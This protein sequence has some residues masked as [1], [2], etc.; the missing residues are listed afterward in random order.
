MKVWIRIIRRNPNCETSQGFMPEFITKLRIFHHKIFE[1]LKSKWQGLWVNPMSHR[2][3]IIYL[4]LRGAT[5]DI[6]IFVAHHC[7]SHRRCHRRCMGFGTYSLS[8]VTLNTCAE[9]RPEKSNLTSS[10]HIAFVLI[11]RH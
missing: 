7:C 9:I 8:Y 4:T 3:E 2:N 5:Y 1:F 10:N 11:V 6:V